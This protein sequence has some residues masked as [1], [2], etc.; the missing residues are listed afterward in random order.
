M[1]PSF[2]HLQINVLGVPRNWPLGSWIGKRVISNC[3]SDCQYLYHI[4]K[5]PGHDLGL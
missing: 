2:C 3:V 1:I 4:V 5:V